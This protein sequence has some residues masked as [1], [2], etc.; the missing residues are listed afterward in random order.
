MAL[1]ILQFPFLSHATS[2]SK[3]LSFTL[4]P[5]KTL[6]PI[7]IKQQEQQERAIRCH[8]VTDLS[9]ST[10][11]SSVDDQSKGEDDDDGLVLVDPSSEEESGGNVPDDAPLGLTV[12][13]K[14]VV[15]YKDGQGELRC[16]Q[17]R[18][19]HRK[20]KSTRVGGA[21]NIR[22]LGMRRSG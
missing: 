4:K 5:T 21:H 12:F 7:H 2:L 22:N 19:P 14:Q 9:S 15:L 1:P 10:L 16:F 17:D 20:M 6:R 8:A 3:P 11:P 18:C 13:D